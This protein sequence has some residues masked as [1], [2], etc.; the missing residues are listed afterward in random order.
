MSLLKSR[1]ARKPHRSEQDPR[2]Y[3]L[4]NSAT[5]VTATAS[6]TPH[7]MGAWAEVTPATATSVTLIEVSADC[8]INATATATLL[9]IGIGGAGAEVA[10]V[11]SIPIGSWLNSSGSTRGA[12]IQIPLT[13]PAGKRVAVRIQSLVASHTA[14]VR[15]HFFN[16]GWMAAA[17]SAVV[18]GA[19]AATSRGIHVGGVATYVEIAAATA[20]HYR[21]LVMVPSASQATLNSGTNAFELGVGAASSEVSIGKIWVEQNSSENIGNG[22]QLPAIAT[23]CIAPGAPAGSRLAIKSSNAANQ[24]DFALIGIPY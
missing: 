4:R 16:G 5:A 9:D 18:I 8:D 12:S 22:F 10:V 19:D 17:A 20:A 1:S 21:Y 3:Y 6:A 15:I 24:L 2:P 7:T 13:I 14:S 23:T 11:S